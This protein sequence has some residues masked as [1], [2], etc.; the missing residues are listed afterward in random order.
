[1]PTALAQFAA[2]IFLGSHPK[3]AAGTEF[4]SRA[5][6]EKRKAAALRASLPLP[7]PCPV[8]STEQCDLKSQVTPPP[9]TTLQTVLL[10][11]WNGRWTG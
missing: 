7:V 2:P 4:L 6:W 1:M 11:R 8:P 9:S 3:R 10:P 5:V